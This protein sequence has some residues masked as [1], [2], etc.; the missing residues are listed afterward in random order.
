MWIWKKDWVQLLTSS[1]ENRVRAEMLDGALKGNEER[2]LSYK[3]TL[4]TYSQS[5]IREKEKSA[6]LALRVKTLEDALVK[7]ED[8]LNIARKAALNLPSLNLSDM[9]EQEDQDKVEEMRKRI[10]AEG[11]D[12]V[13]AQELEK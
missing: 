11:A 8:E 4:N 10:K 13:L 2:I 6:E 9:F 1:H 12:M 7:K 5:L 3:K